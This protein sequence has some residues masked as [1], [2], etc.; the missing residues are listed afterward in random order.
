MNWLDWL[1]IA[2]IALSTLQG[3]RHGLLVGVAKMAGLLAG[4]VVAYSYYRPVTDFLSAHWHLEKIMLPLTGPFL[5]FWQPVEDVVSPLAVPEK[6]MSGDYITKIVAYSVLEALT[7]LVLL[8]AAVWL[9]NAAGLILTRVADFSLLGPLNH[10]GGL[11][12]GFLKGVLVVVIILALMNLFMGNYLITP[13]MA[14]L[15]GKAFKNSAL[16]PYF[17]PF[18]D[19]LNQTLAGIIPRNNIL[20]GQV[21]SI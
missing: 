10:L 17:K 15:E 11:I 4:L 19:I 8:L 3:L 2:V 13:G 6:L 18:I 1:I 20:P 12:F 14:G 9:V 16:L 5:R 21:N 7:F